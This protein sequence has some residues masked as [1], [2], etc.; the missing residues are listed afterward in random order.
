MRVVTGSRKSL[1]VV[2][3]KFLDGKVVEYSTD[4]ME[5]VDLSY[6]ISIHKS[7]GAE[8]PVV[9]IPILKEHYIML[10][11]NLLYTA[12]S[13]AKQKVILIGQKQAIFMAIHNSDVD[14]RNTVLS[15]RINA[16]YAR[17]KR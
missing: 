17:A 3:I 11:R 1:T 15:D 9:I 14:K 7:Q 5:N 13:R 8:F 4:M 2:E 12:I 16:Y 6:C 10:R